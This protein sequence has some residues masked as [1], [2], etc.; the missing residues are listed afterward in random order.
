MTP[1]LLPPGLTLGRASSCLSCSLLV[2]PLPDLPSTHL[3]FLL[4]SGG[5]V[6][7]GGSVARSLSPPDLPLTVPAEPKEEEKRKR[8]GESLTGWS[9]VLVAMGRNLG[10]LVWGS[11]SIDLGLKKRGGHPNKK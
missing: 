6:S 7:S 3:W 2:D 4:S 8:E 11:E 10:V 1:S 9:L 5:V